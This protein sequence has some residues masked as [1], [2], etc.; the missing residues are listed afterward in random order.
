MNQQ[1]LKLTDFDYAIADHHIQMLKASLPYMEPSEQRT[2]SMFV[3]LRELVSTI[4]F[5]D[6]NELG[7][8]SICSLDQ[9]QTSATNML[10][11]VK[12]YASPK[13]Q[14]L[15]DLLTRL[16]S[17]RQSKQ[18]RMPLTWEQLLSVMP[19]E[20]QSRFETIQLMMQAL[21]QT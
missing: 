3:K 8:M 6:H 2:L 21:A 15:I 9:S 7:M 5:Y 10:T 4:R 1:E 12:P 14:E 11:A 19:A 17:N 13:E 16:L 20:Q 18:G